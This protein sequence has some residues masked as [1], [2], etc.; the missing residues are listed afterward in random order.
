MVKIW[1]AI[2]A[3]CALT[4]VAAMQPFNILFAFWASFFIWLL[5]DRIVPLI[6]VFFGTWIIYALYD[7]VRFVIHERRRNKIPG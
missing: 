1:R 2:T 5:W 4:F 3:F 7:A 6:I